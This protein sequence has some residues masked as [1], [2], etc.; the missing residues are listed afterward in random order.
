LKYNN[1]G[2][3][4]GGPIKKNKIFFLWSEEWRF[5][6]RGV[7]VT[8][9][10]PTAAEK[11]GDFSGTL[12][13]PRPKD[14][15]L[16]GKCDEKGKVGG[17]FR[18]CYPGDKIPAN[19]L[20]PAGLALLKIYPDPNAGGNLWVGAPTQPIRT[21]QDS[22][23]GDANLTSKMNLMV[24][25]INEKWT[26]GQNTQNWGDVPF[27]TLSDDW[28][29]PSNSLAIKLSNTIGTTAVN[30]FQFSRAGNDIFI[31]TADHST[32]LVN[33]INSKFPTVFPHSDNVPALMWGPGGWDNIWHQAPWQNHEDLFIW[34][35]DFSK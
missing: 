33:D 7:A 30:D 23:R 13:N 1:F 9:H 25:Y 19:R 3:N 4:F 11:A 15:F 18:G 2:G 29:Q 17:D 21:R 8:G 31:S 5:E 20:S 35:D 16:P 32:G 10:V 14:P 22:I 26:H 12:T 34:K 27:P 24:R 6:D 28:S